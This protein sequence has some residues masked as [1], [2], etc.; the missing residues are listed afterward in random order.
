MSI[1]VLT[2][3]YDNA[4]TGANTQETELTAAA[5]GKRGVRRL[6]SLHLPG[7]QRG[8][9]A[10]PLIV[11]GVQMPDG[12]RRDL[13]LVATMGNLIF[14]FD[15]NDGTQL[16]TR[17]LG[18]PIGGNKSID[19]YRINDHW[20]ILSTPVIDAAA[21]V[22][23]LCAWTSPD[24]SV[25]KARH[26]LHAVRITTGQDVHAAP[27][28]FEGAVY[29]PGHGAPRQAFASA[30]RKQRASLLLQ[31]NTVFV[32]F[33]SLQETSRQARGWIIACDV[34]AWSITAVW[35]SAAKGFGAGIWQ[36]GSGLVS[37][38]QGHI[39]CMTGNGTF[40]AQ[41]DWAESILKLRYTPPAGGQK[42]GS[43]AVA[44]WFT[45]WTDDARVG[46]DR[47]GDAFDHPSPTNRR[48]YTEDVNAGWDDMD[49]GSGGPI[50]AADHGLILGAGKDGVL[51]VAKANDMGKTKPHDLDKPQANYQRLA[52]APIWF[53][54]FPGFDVKPAPDDISALNQH[55][56]GR[57]H[58]QHAA[59]LLWNSRE[60]GTMLFCW[61]ENSE[62]RA[63]TL[64]AN[65]KATYLACSAE[66]ASAQAT[67]QFGGMPG[68]MMCLTSNG[69]VA[70]TGV[71]WACIPYG[72][73][74][75]TVTNGRLL[76]YDATTFGTF[77]DGSKQ[78]RV[79]WDSQDWNLTFLF[80]K[81]TPPVVANGKVYVPTYGARI[82]VY[83]LA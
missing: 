72:D 71:V 76:A 81:F 45:P 60:H 48:V 40:D 34:R 36:A 42:T 12:K 2:R 22:M 5:V 55:F 79:L 1:S 78:L 33:G 3:A 10:Q 41:T 83:G 9:E 77:G 20:G 43:L 61:G 35:A 30:G 14:G 4:R 29:D 11:A 67:G 17:A 7:D 28:D 15:A 37:D 49:L 74:N 13:L 19:E 44:D 27:I 47:S 66:V 70:N 56:F 6:F 62:L 58:H 75:T 23:Y 8:A 25:G 59:P 31:A 82:D 69:A 32:A 53:T 26:G 57:T 64:A 63:W 54:F 52:A 51:F 46:L 50:L 73:A 39:F 38:A 18:T 24:G 80:C 65:G 21:G 16:W 68:G